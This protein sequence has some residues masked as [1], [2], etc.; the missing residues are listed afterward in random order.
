MILMAMRKHDRSNV[1]A[2]LFQIGNVRYDEVYAK[3]FGFR[4][5]HARVNDENVVAETKHHHVHS[6]FAEAAKGN[7]CEGLRGLT[8]K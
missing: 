5:H 8:Q 7:C 4:E 2:I 3:K 6:K 1:R